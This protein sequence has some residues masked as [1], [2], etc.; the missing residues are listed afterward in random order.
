MD[1]KDS[2]QQDASAQSTARIT[3]SSGSKQIINC[4]RKS[5]NHHHHN[6]DFFGNVQSVNLDEYQYVVKAAV[7]AAA[8][9]AAAAI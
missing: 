7:A 6:G 5:L 1:T 9:A 2:E 8:A 3:D 4:D